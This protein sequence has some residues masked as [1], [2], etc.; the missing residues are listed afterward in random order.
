MPYL[1]P[2]VTFESTRLPQLVTA[3][4]PSAPARTDL[5]P[6]RTEPGAGM[7]ERKEHLRIRPL[8]GEWR[9]ITELTNWVGRELNQTTGYPGS[10]EVTR[11]E[12]I[13]AALDTYLPA[14]Q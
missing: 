3:R 1:A 10:A 4:R 2:W 7:T 11:S 5:F 6:W 12:V 8:A 14:T 9:V 13:E